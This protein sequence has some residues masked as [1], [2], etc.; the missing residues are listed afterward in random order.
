M[1]CRV[2]DALIDTNL[3][4]HNRDGAVVIIV[5]LDVL[6][7]VL[8][9][10]PG[11]LEIGGIAQHHDKLLSAPALRAHADALIT[12]DRAE[13]VLNGLHPFGE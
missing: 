2:A 1:L 10:Q 5:D 8:Q 7:I 3:T 6:V 4:Q 12:Q 11:R 9:R 13:I